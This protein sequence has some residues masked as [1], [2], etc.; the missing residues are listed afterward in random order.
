MVHLIEFILAFPHNDMVRLLNALQDPFKKDIL[1]SLITTAI[2]EKN[3]SD[4]EEKE[5]L[6]FFTSI[7][8]ADLEKQEVLLDPL[9]IE[10]IAFNNELASAWKAATKKEEQ[11]E[12]KRFDQDARLDILIELLQQCLPCEKVTI[13]SLLKKLD[14]LSQTYM[15][16]NCGYAANTV[17][18]LYTVI[19]IA[20]KERESV[21]TENVPKSPPPSP[22]LEQLLGDEFDK[23][24]VDENKEQKSLVSAVVT[25]LQTQL[26]TQTEEVHKEKIKKVTYQFNICS[27]LYEDKGEKH[28]DMCC[29]LDCE[30]KLFK[31]TLESFIEDAMRHDKANFPEEYFSNKNPCMKLLVDFGDAT[32]PIHRVVTK[33][34]CIKKVLAQYE[35]ALLFQAILYDIGKNAAQRLEVFL[36]VY[37]SQNHKLREKVGNESIDNTTKI[38]LENIS[39]IL[40]ARKTYYSLPSGNWR[41]TLFSQALACYLMPRQRAPEVSVVSAQAKLNAK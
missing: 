28:I 2:H 35:L 19:A 11:K 37:M 7:A 41:F 9:M 38:F 17:T 6:K 13:E 30:L 15:D 36:K 26:Q 20:K 40:N 32:N 4:E 8:N 18:A 16:F 5:I 14:C 39:V 25:Q 24:I 34:E 3:I 12:E 29:L 23:S 22:L 1:L 27:S 33:N 21:V 31:M 10:L